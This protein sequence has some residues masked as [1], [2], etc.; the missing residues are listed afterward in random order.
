MDVAE[1]LHFLMYEDA[2]LATNQPVQI[3]CA[4]RK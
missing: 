3:Y 2:T 4:R 1:E